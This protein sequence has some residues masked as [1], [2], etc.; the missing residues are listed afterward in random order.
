MNIF[1]ID[2]IAVLGDSGAVTK[3]VDNM[4]EC[5]VIYIP[6]DFGDL[7][8]NIELDYYALGLTALEL[9]GIWSPIKGSMTKASILSAI[10]SS[11]VAEFFTNLNF[12]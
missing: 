2:D 1:L 10:D 4:R 5:S 9:L 7:K 3:F 8:A 6:I 11:P 12:T